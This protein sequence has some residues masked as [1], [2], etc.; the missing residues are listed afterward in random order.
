MNKRKTVWQS[1]ITGVHFSMGGMAGI[2]SVLGFGGG[3]MWALDLFS[4]FRTQYLMGLL[5][6]MMICLCFKRWRSLGIYAVLF[7][8]NLWVVWP[9]V[10][11]VDARNDF[12]GVEMRDSVS[13][14]NSIGRVKI[15]HFNVLSSNK[16]RG[17]LIDYINESGAALVFL[18]EVTPA[19][20]M[21][22]L[23][24]C[25]NYRLEVEGSRDDN[26]G[27]MMLVRKDWRGK[28]SNARWETEVAGVDVKLPVILADVEM[29]GRKVSMMSMHTIPPMGLKSAG[30]NG[31]QLAAARQWSDGKVGAHVLI[32]DLNATSWSYGF[33]ALVDG[34]KL[35]DSTVGFGWGL[36]WPTGLP[37]WIGIGL[38]HCLVSDEVVV[39]SRELVD[40]RLGSDHRG[41]LIE[42]GVRVE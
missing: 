42:L 9:Y 38:D 12:S 14:V 20:V 26:F 21:E 40:E 11:G 7:G 31:R 19:W 17:E 6:A 35:R 30:L 1:I 15:L 33:G 4:H 23:K 18:Q 3:I 2:A 25:G 29:S 36:S 41:L 5:L 13:G 22:V 27:I 16:R 28:V 39:M 10:V 34:G 8:L 37:C 32:G 24:G